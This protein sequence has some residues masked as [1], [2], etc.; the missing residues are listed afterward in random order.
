MSAN[1]TNSSSDLQLYRRL[2]GYVAPYRQVFLLSILAM[3]IVAV[4][5]PAVAALMEPMFDGAFIDKNRE[6]MV[7][8]PLMLVGVFFVRSLGSF[9]SNAALQVVSNKVVRDLRG[10]MYQCL[11]RLPLNYFDR[12]TS[13][14]LMSRFTYDVTQLRE[15]SVYVL[16]VLL[17][18]ALAVVGLIAW[19][20]YLNWQL[21]LA[22]LVAAPLIVA[23]MSVI[24][25][26]LR[27]MS[28]A[29]QNTMGE[30]HHSLDESI[31]ATREMRLYDSYEQMG[32]AFDQVADKNRRYNIKFGMAAAAS[33]PSVQLIA[34][35]ALSTIVYFGAQLAIADRITVGEF[36]SF[37]TAMALLLTPLRHLATIN[38]SLQRGMAAAETVFAL[39][40]QPPEQDTGRVDLG[41]ARG[42]IVFRDVSFSYDSERG[43][44]LRNINLDIKPGE[45]V[46]LVGASGSG[47]STLVSL[48]PRFY[49]LQ[50]GAIFIDDQD[51]REVTLASLRDNIAMVRQDVVLLNDTVRNNIAFGALKR[52]TDDVAIRAAAEAAQAMDF[53]DKLP[54]G[55]D[56]VIGGEGTSLSGGQRQR[57]AIA[58]ALLKDAPILILDEA[59]SAL[60]SESEQQFQRAMQAVMKDRTCIIIAHRLSTVQQVDRLIVLDHGRIVESGTHEE[61]MRRDGAYARLYSLQFT[62]NAESATV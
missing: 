50:Q 46:A 58:R 28:R 51:I 43:Y 30:I 12:H 39:M 36:V 49:E 15:A 48:L 6:T 38:E 57:L 34:A 20:F 56:T 4:T 61:L 8:V 26:R 18:D 60:D 47:K 19:M 32:N 29:V 53:I 16:T 52:G 14:S 10:D 5:N 45:S 25:K 33:S 37:F 2:L 44:A 31:Q 21:T 17:R 55:L 9:I 1:P 7:Q 62:A 23:V 35:V 42:E 40:D 24:R 13:G 11:M 27:R 22:V 3:V 54:Q 41:R 59:T